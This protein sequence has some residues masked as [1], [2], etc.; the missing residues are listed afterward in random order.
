MGATNTTAALR[1]D[2][3]TTHASAAAKNGGYETFHRT[4]Q[5]EPQP[6]QPYANQREPRSDEGEK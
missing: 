3:A 1:V 2:A 4:N 6:E 5:D